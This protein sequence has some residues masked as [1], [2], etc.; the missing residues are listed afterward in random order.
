MAPLRFEQI[1]STERFGIAESLR[2]ILSRWVH[3][4]RDQAG[5]PTSAQLEALRI[6]HNE[7]A[8][9]IA[10]LA[11]R[12][13]VKHQSM[14]LSIEQLAAGQTILKSADPNGHRNRIVRTTAK[15]RSLLRQQ[16]RARALWIAQLLQACS[17][18]EVNQVIAAIDVLERLLD[19]V[20][21]N[22][23]HA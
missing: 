12:R 3:M 18:E 7:G 17:A 20:P 14:R 23:K 19:R 16:Q 1:D 22:V 8:S 13:S 21:K 10:A 9:S 2:Q 15:G 11:H 6:L 5:T 4:T